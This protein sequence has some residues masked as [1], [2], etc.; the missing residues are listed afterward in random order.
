MILFVKTKAKRQA[1]VNGAPRTA[2]MRPAVAAQLLLLQV[3]ADPAGAG[4][5]LQ[6]RI[7]AML[8]QSRAAETAPP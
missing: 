1:G 4:A 3:S 8:F 7:H 5:A 2:D 6:R